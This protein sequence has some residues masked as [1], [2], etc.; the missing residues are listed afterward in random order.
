MAAEICMHDIYRYI[1]IDTHTLRVDTHVYLR[2]S[3]SAHAA[4]C[5]RGQKERR[6]ER[7]AQDARQCVHLSSRQKKEGRENRAEADMEKKR[8]IRSENL[9]SVSTSREN[10]ERETAGE[11]KT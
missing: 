7:R 5:E 1:D 2:V 4:L 6:E 9:F 8:E 10:R 11:M 3:P